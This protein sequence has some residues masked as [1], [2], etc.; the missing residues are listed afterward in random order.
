MTFVAIGALRV[1]T[2]DIWHAHS[3]YEMYGKFDNVT[4]NV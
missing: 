3:V 4:C 1:S 2:Y